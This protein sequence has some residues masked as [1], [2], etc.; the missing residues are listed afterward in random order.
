MGLVLL[1][2]V[3]QPFGGHPSSR[4]LSIFYHFSD[5]DEKTCISPRIL[6]KKLHKPRS[7]G[8]AWQGPPRTWSHAVDREERRHAHF[9]PS[10]MFY[11]IPTIFKVHEG[12][13]YLPVAVEGCPSR[14]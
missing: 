4:E 12:E 11:C 10:L 5:L 2:A 9:A 7:S 3:P 1:V 6:L 13:P 14:G 8:S